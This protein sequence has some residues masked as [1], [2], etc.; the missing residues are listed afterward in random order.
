MK[1]KAISAFN[2]KLKLKLTEAE[3]GKNDCETSAKNQNDFY[4]EAYETINL[5]FKG[6]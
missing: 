3:L 6:F 5:Q 4:K 2:L 1:C